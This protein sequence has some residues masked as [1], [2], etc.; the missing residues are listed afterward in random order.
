[1][2][3]GDCP[4]SS[5]LT[6]FANYQTWKFRMKMVL[7]RNN[8]WQYVDP[9]SN[10][11]PVRG[12]PT[13]IAQGRVKALTD[14]VLSIKKDIYFIVQLCVDP[15]DAWNRLAA[16]YQTGNTA[17]RLMLKDKLNSIRLHEGGSVSEYLTQLQSIQAELVG[18]G[19]QVPEAE[20]VE[21]M[22]NSLPPSF[23]S[24]YQSFCTSAVLPTFEQVSAR[25]L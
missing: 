2:A 24:V 1:M 19:Q 16:R 6:G 20:I 25:L 15:R 23:D 17:S 18:I 8:V 11:V 13:D 3:S 10:N 22:L 14:I 12:E 5:K 21:R 9:T 7:L 4:E